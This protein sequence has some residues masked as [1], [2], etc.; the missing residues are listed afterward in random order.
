[1]PPEQR[2]RIQNT[3]RQTGQKKPERRPQKRAVSFSG[4]CA[5]PDIDGYFFHHM[6]P[7]AYYC[8][9]FVLHIDNTDGGRMRMRIGDDEYVE[10]DIVPGENVVQVERL[11]PAGTRIKLQLINKTTAAGL[12]VAWNGECQ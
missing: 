7:C 3:R 10:R 5:T 1:M 2:Q 8:K 11:V 4:Y 12:W 9:S 6:A